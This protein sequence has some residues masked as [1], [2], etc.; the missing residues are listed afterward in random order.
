MVV[1]FMALKGFWGGIGSADLAYG[2][3]DDFDTGT[4]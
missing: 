4:Q 2:L 3:P 1:V